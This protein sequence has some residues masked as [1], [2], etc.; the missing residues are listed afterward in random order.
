MK[1]LFTLIVLTLLSTTAMAHS[2]GTN[3]SG[4]HIDHRTGVMHCH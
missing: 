4:C 2:G 3:A 1:T